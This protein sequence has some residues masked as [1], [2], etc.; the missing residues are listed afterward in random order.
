LEQLAEVCRLS[1][2]PVFAI[3]G[4]TGAS[5]LDVLRAGSY[6]IAVIGSILDRADAA[7]ATR[8]MMTALRP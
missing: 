8:A 3:G 5:V 7:A 6:G 2:I 4:I 1:A